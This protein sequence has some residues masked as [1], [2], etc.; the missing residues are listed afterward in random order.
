MG[1]SRGE[2]LRADVVIGDRYGTSCAALLP[3]MVEETMSRLGYSVGCNKPYA[4]GFITE[5]YGNPA[6]GLHAIQLEL[7]RAL[8]M[9]ERRFEHPA[10][11]GPLAPGL[12]MHPGELSAL[13]IPQ[14][15]P[16]RTAA[17]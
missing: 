6:A 4:G 9:D 2:P 1:V 15:R 8:Y 14:L 17:Q 16:Y 12:Q 5:H 11:F 7:N 10:S 3:D 13:P